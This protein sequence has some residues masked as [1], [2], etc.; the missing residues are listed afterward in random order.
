MFERKHFNRQIIDK[1]W[2]IYYK[3]AGK[4]FYGPC[5]FFQ[6][7]NNDLYLASEGFNDW[8]SVSV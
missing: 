7:N 2:L 6:E 4:V 3:T 1:L 8:R 5:K